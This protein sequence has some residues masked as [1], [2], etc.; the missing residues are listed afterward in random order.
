M[1]VLSRPSKY[2]VHPLA[3]TCHSESEFAI[4][5]LRLR[6]KVP[7]PTDSDSNS[8]SDFRLLSPDEQQWTSGHRAYR[9]KLCQ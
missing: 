6:A 2:A 1:H 8:N 5:Q 9:V 7:T 4:F 3:N